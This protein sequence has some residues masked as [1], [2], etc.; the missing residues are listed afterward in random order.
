MGIKRLAD[1][2]VHPSRQQNFSSSSNHFAKK[3]RPNPSNRAERASNSKAV[4]PLKSQ[5]RN[6]SRMLQH[7]ENLPADVRI[8]K[9]RAL[10][11]YQADLEEALEAKRSNERI[12]RYHMVRFFGIS[13]SICGKESI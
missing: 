13:S 7:S 5:I 1:E 4:N 6:L 10:A 8:E 2:E 9:E 11:S 3:S 12:S